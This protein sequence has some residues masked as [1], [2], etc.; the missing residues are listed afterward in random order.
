MLDI[1]LTFAPTIKRSMLKRTFLSLLVSIFVAVGGNSQEVIKGIVVDSENSLPIENAIIGA[2]R[3]DKR[4]VITDRTGHFQYSCPKKSRLKVRCMGYKTLMVDWLDSDTIRLKPLSQTLQEVVV[5]AQESKGL[6]AASVISKN[7][8][9]HLQ[10]SSFSDLLSL[11]PGGMTQDPHLTSPNHIQL[12]QVDTPSKNYN[13]SSQG[14]RFMLDGAPMENSVNMQFL[15]GGH[16]MKVASNRVNSGVDMR[17]ISTDDIEKVEIVRGIPSVEYGDLTSG[18]VKIER[19]YG[20][21]RLR[22]RLKADMKSKL[23]YLSKGWETQRGWGFN[24]S[25]DYLNAKSDP[26]DLMSTYRRIS[27][28]GRLRYAI[29]SASLKGRVTSAF[30]YT[31]SIDD[32][33]EDPELNYGYPNIYKSNQNNFSWNANLHLMPWR[34]KW[35]NS[36][37]AM[38]SA[39]MQKNKTERERYVMLQRPTPAAVTMTEGESDAVILPY[40]YFATQSSDG[41]PVYLFAK[42][43]TDFTIPGFLTSNRFLLGATY[44]YSKNFGRGQ[45]FD[46]SRPV[47]PGVSNRPRD[48]RD[49]PSMQTLSSFA[50]FDWRQNTICGLFR[51]SGGV[52]TQQF[53]NINK[54]RSLHHKIYIDPRVNI[55]WTYHPA[56]TSSFSISILGG[57]GQHTLMPSMSQLYPA[58]DYLDIVELNYYH[59]RPEYRR[60]YLQTYIVDP[61]NRQLMAARNLKKEIGIDLSFK[62]HRLSLT[63]FH[64]RMSSG[65]RTSGI[66]ESFAYKKFDTSSL[67]AAQVTAPPDIATLPYKE[68][69]DLRSLGTTTNGSETLK[70]GV[71]L[72]YSSPRFPVILTRL[73]ITGAYF[74]STYRNS[75][76]EYERLPI[77]IGQVQYPYV[78]IYDMVGGRE[79]DRA[80]T[81]FTFD[82]YIPKLDLS[83]SLSAQCMWTNSSRS[84]PESKYPRAYIDIEG[85]EHPFTDESLKDPMLQY[86]VRKLS[87]TLYRKERE[88]FCM[89]LN[90]K[91]TKELFNERMNVALF[92]DKIWDYSPDFEIYG[93]TNR[94]YVNPYFGLEINCKL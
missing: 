17:T 52:R 91:V 38:F 41:R 55:G 61:T 62:K 59:S 3:Y 56:S 27:F 66:Y 19:K 90:L 93:H 7:A 65:F 58:L 54:S 16:S 69:H 43:K 48:L 42:L 84:M 40:D 44:N 34:L 21:R 88:P 30:D 75:Q 72:T 47:Y 73:T 64:E 33:K 25:S 50:E 68:V 89:H 92:C 49:I 57:I 37:E 9:K 63:Y 32:D 78:G 28:S 1:R 67:D 23:F 45:I 4:V 39:S 20:G 79:A 5:T 10:P 46:M 29:K 6:T 8:M 74:K 24:L 81:N 77:M 60:M 36:F 70:R 15:A 71:E 18:L 53:M 12:R 31:G 82:T 51:F 87:P 13:T 86:L 22:A 35:W 2:S 11:L 83:F 26:R 94:R 76:A 85:K 14:T 80:N